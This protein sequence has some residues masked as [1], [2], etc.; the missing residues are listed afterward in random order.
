MGTTTIVG[1]LINL[2]NGKTYS[3]SSMLNPQTAYGEDLVT[4]MTYIQNNENG[5][6]KLNSTVIEALN[7]IIIKNCAKAN[8]SPSQIYE[9]TIVGN[10]VMHHIFLI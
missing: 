1:Y 5:L 6:K 10:S 4:R 8:I 2:N 7:E 9:A 3:A